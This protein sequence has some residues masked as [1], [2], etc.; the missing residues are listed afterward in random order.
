MGYATG[1]KQYYNQLGLNI[2]NIRAFYDFNI[3]SGNQLVNAFW[4]TNGINGTI[5][6][7]GNFYSTSGCGAF[8][9]GKFVKINSNLDLAT[10]TVFLSYE[11][12]RSGV[13]EI[14]FSTFSGNSFANSS[15][16][17]LGI[18][19]ANKLYFEYWNSV[20]GP[21][22]FTFS[23]IVGDKNL[24]SVTK[25]DS[26]IFFSYFDANSKKSTIQQDLIY[27]N[28]FINADNWFIGGVPNK[29]YYINAQ[30]FSGYIDDFVLISGDLDQNYQ[31][32]LYSGFFS[33]YGTGIQTLTQVCSNLIYLSG[34]N[35]GLSTGNIGF[36]TVE[37]GSVTD[38]CG[39]TNTTYSWENVTGIISGVYF[40]PI[41][42]LGS[43][44]VNYT[45]I[46][47]PQLYIDSGYLFSL[48]LN[49]ISLLY[50]IDNQDFVDFY[51][52]TGLFQDTTRNKIAQY[53]ALND[54][55]FLDKNYT[56]GDLSASLNGQLQLESGYQV[57]PSGYSDIY[58]LTGNYFISGNWIY[59]T[60]FFESTDYILYDFINKNLSAV[61]FTGHTSG[62]T[63]S[64]ISTFAGKLI[65]L[66]G[67]KLASGIDYTLPNTLNL[68]V[69]SGNNVMFA[70][71][72]T[73]N[74]IYTSGSTG[75]LSYPTK[76]L[77]NT[78]WAYLNGVRLAQNGDYV[79]N[80]SLD[81][82]SGNYIEPNFKNIIY[83]N[84][85]DFFNI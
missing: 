85:D 34:I 35:T 15:G 33:H 23:H 31:N 3:Q 4:A 14:L 56:S 18:N 54:V 9:T 42:G 36:Q 40:V 30:N 24:I 28:N 74:S 12:A 52:L 41:S 81:L 62:T 67:Q 51:A 84:S 49:Q 57:V 16:F 45:G 76:F 21:Q 10:W 26:S 78:S 53:N 70:L 11:R 25:N 59:S 38:G 77:R 19:E 55:F 13:D 7:S 61:Y 48:G 6:N 83:N 69:D 1:F 72:L 66:N 63:F 29:P 64:P 43:E 79:E 5:N 80:S 68:T 50:P 17:L 2:N 73:G 47:D 20:D 27:Q 22:I 46:G 75:F 58:K 39:I 82:L 71:T 65:F 60:G 32:I 44:C 8:N 37:V